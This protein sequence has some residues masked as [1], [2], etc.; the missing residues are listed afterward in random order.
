ML[1]GCN[2]VT[3]PAV[4]VNDSLDEALNRVTEVA[5][6]ILVPDPD[7]DPVAEGCVKEVGHYHLVLR[8]ELPPKQLSFS[9]RFPTKFCFLTSVASTPRA[10]EGDCP[11]R[12]E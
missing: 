4:L 1:G 5:S 11:N 9:Y 6:R 10:P 2:R 7:T 3:V 12:L 8:K